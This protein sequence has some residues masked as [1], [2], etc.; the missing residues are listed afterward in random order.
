MKKSALGGLI[1]FA[2]AYVFALPYITLYHIKQ[3]VDERDSAALSEHIDFPSV[4]QSLKDQLNAMLMG[5]M[6]SDDMKN[7]PFAALGMALAG[8]V[9]DKMVE[10]YV[11]PA[12]V[13]QLLAGEKPSLKNARKIK[14]AADNADNTAAQEPATEKPLADVA[15]GY[16]STSRFEV[17]DKKKGTRVVLR[18]QGL[19]WRVTFPRIAGRAL[20]AIA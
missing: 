3:A 14:H 12:G 6:H 16:K 20:G 19:T 18:R 10:A 13:E 2:V 11:T 5:K 7:N 1:F 15:M 9:V 8:P 4:R 17:E